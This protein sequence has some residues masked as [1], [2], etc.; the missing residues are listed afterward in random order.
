MT[1]KELRQAAG[2]S[3][4]EFSEYFNIP[5]RTIEDWEAGKRKCPAYLVELIEWKLELQQLI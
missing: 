5:Y 4:K 1:I 3:R 2:M